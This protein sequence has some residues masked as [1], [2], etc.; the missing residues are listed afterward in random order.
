MK[1]VLVLGGGY[2]SLS[3]LK[4]LPQLCLEKAEFT[5][6]SQSGS[7][8]TS[9]LLHESVSSDKAIS[10]PY[11]TILP[12]GVKFVQ[13]TIL[14]IQDHQVIGQNATYSYDM[15]VVGLG[16]S[17]D[18][19]G[20][21]GITQYAHPMV[22]LTNCQAIHAQLRRV[23]QDGL[24][25]FGDLP[26]V[27]CGGGFSG[28]ELIASLAEDLPHMC[29]A[30]GIDPARIKLTCVEAMSK[31]LPMFPDALIE[32]GV[33]YLEN[34]GVKFEVGAKILA[35]KENGVLVEQNGEQ[36]IIESCFTFWSAGV[37]G[38]E[39][40]AKSPFFTSG[41][42]KVE[43]SAFLQPINQ[44]NQDRMNDIFV[45]GDCAALKDPV[46]GRFYPPTAQ[47]A[48]QQGQ[49]LAKVFQAK[50][51][52]ES[53]AQEFHYASRGTVCSLGSKYAIG[54]VGNRQI[55]GAL[56]IWIKRFVE[57]TWVAKLKGVLRALFT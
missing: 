21:E 3:F 22:N 48:L 28:I 24:K 49:Y 14:E 4:H 7:H 18:D 13:D 44:E 15:L 27:V 5:L 20:I 30:Y 29:Q 26:F 25:D 11:S 19:F 32:K 46:S 17:S 8:Y 2:A 39:V 10:H 37:K 56:A 41:R 36:R 33:N 23:L 51:D 38:N 55:D 12:K 45:I 54:L 40:I 9:V 50:L 52:G 47:I 16:F 6:I 53:L 35:V 1:K 31:V 43:V 57:W 42:S 34:L